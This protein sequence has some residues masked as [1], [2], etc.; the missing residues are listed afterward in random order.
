M[1]LEIRRI[2]LWSVIKIAF[3]LYLILGLFFGLLYAAFLGFVGRFLEA[4][5][6]EEFSSPLGPLSGIALIFIA[7]F[8][9]FFVATFYTILTVMVVGLYNGVAR[10]TGGIKVN[11]LAEPKE[12]QA[13]EPVKEA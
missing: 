2:D 6:L 12:P 8:I 9:A 10:W 3:I 4:L 5:G 11:L 7:G 13:A 1:E